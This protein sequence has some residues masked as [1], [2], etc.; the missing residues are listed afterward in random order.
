[1][2]SIIG[3]HINVGVGTGN[4][5]HNDPT[6]FRHHTKTLVALIKRDTSTHYLTRRCCVQ[7][8][9]PGSN[10]I[11]FGNRFF[12]S[13][14]AGKCGAAYGIIIWEGKKI[15]PKVQLNAC[16]LGTETSKIKIVNNHYR[17]ESL[18]FYNKINW[19]ITKIPMFVVNYVV[20]HEYVH[21][22]ETN[23]TQQFR[24]FNRA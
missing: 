5:P 24:G 23:D 18:I 12:L 15:F 21:L 4:H 2:V 10:E 14:E 6:G 11:H 17:W 22:I 1:M 16:N 8:E 13:I 20:V 7:V 9:S 3:H 19:R